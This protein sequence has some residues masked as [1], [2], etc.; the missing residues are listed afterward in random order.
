MKQLL[1]RVVL[2]G[3]LSTLIWLVERQVVHGQSNSLPDSLRLILID[4]EKNTK[5]SILHK[6]AKE[7]QVLCTKNI[8]DS[9]LS[10]KL[11]IIDSLLVNGAQINDSMILC[12]ATT[13]AQS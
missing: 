6:A 13:L 5:D 1:H 2:L 8:I 12:Y 3:L 4:I 7:V 9:S 10:K 11:F